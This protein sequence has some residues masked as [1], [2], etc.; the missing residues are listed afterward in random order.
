[1]DRIDTQIRQRQQEIN[2]AIRASFKED[3]TAR[4]AVEMTE[5]AFEKAVAEQGL[6]VFTI[7]GLNAYKQELL[8]AIEGKKFPLDQL[9]KAAKNLGALQKVQKTDKN[10]KK[11]T[12]YVK[13]GEDPK[14][15]HPAAKPEAAGQE[16]EGMEMSHGHKQLIQNK[17]DLHKRVAMAMEHEQDPDRK[18]ELMAHHTRLT[19]E[20]A[21]LSGGGKQSGE[22][23]AD[24]KLGRAM[25]DHDKGSNA[26]K[27][28]AEQYIRERA[29]SGGDD[30]GTKAAQ[31]RVEKMGAEKPKEDN[32]Q[33]L[34]AMA[35]KA[36][37]LSRKAH[38]TKD[39]AKHEAAAK[40]HREA[41][42]AVGAAGHKH[43]ANVHKDFAEDH[44]RHAKNVKSEYNSEY[45]DVIKFAKEQLSS[46][47]STTGGQQ[48]GKGYESHTKTPEEGKAVI[49]RQKALLANPKS[50]AGAKKRAQEII[51][52]EMKKHGAAIGVN[53]EAV[54]KIV[55]DQKANPGDKLIDGPHI[56]KEE[57]KAE[58]VNDPNHPA[59]SIGTPEL[60]AMTKLP[61]GPGHP[62]K[63]A[64][65][66]ATAKA[67]LKRRG[68]S[69]EG[70]GKEEGD[71]FVP[72]EFK[73]EPLKEGDKFPGSDG[74]WKK[75]HEIKDGKATLLDSTGMGYMRNDSKGGG[76]HSLDD[77]QKMKDAYHKGKHD[78]EQ[79]HA[80]RIHGIAKKL[81]IH[82]IK[83]NDL[84]S[85]GHALRSIEEH[86][87]GM[88]VKDRSIG[89]T[90]YGS[91][92]LRHSQSGNAFSFHTNQRRYKPTIG[93]TDHDPIQVHI[94]GGIK[95]EHSRE[96]SS[97]AEMAFEKFKPGSKAYTD[98][99]TNYSTVHL[100]HNGWTNTALTDD[101]IK[102]LH[103]SGSKAQ[104]KKPSSKK[105]D[106]ALEK[107]LDTLLKKG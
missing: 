30:L 102:K 94:G 97:L 13:R 49:E 9:E 100:S 8:K 24:V 96:L 3:V 92:E 29:S 34:L 53:K 48:T 80:K 105:G 71:D 32:T 7:E 50:P 84:T 47:M 41:E 76:V 81:D 14:K 86:S 54:K 20:I 107:A 82:K 46:Q 15:E 87:K 61:V 59:R 42:K 72:K 98:Y 19:K 104:D 95:S 62:S 67:E 79:A 40:A 56:K 35:N 33:Q 66:V 51:D 31:K 73:S 52:A 60:K 1:M 39:A 16:K 58:N 74:Q 6:E 93:S 45:H 27:R 26:E 57:P 70:E 37:S 99:G 68:I 44:E 22:E 69:D 4:P 75:V 63:N 89:G 101:G 38:G 5:E 43:S 78:E 36:H 88:N 11:I 12:V 28:A 90:Y 21:H 77:V 10:G 25:A 103:G 85:L 65:K 91:T 64:G 106:S 83:P 23:H 2:K 17:Q 55:K 18:A